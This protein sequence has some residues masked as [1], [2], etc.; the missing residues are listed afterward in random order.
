MTAP[1]EKLA[2]SLSALQELQRDGRRA[3]QSKEFSRVHRARLVKY[4]F[5]QEVMKGWGISSSPHTKQGD[6]TSLYA[7]FWEFFASYCNNRF[8]ARW[9]L[10]PEQSIFLH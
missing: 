3:F 9:H 7:S 4:G 6:R 8:K 1:N 10:S 2:L 5:L